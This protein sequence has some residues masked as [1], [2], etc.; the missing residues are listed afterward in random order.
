[1]NKLLASAGLAGAITGASIG[2]YNYGKQNNEPV[3]VK[4]IEESLGDKKRYVVYDPNSFGK[5]N[6]IGSFGVLDVKGTAKNYS[7]YIVESES[8][9]VVASNLKIVEDQVYSIDIIPGCDPKPEPTPIDPDPTSA[10]VPWGITKVKA[11]IAREV[12]DGGEV[13]VCVADTGTDY[14]HPDIKPNLVGGSNH[15]NDWSWLDDQGHGTHVAGTISA[16]LNDRDVVGVSNAKIY[17]AKVLDRYGRGLGSWI[18]E[19][20]VS[21]VEAGAD[22]I[23]MSL[24]SPESAGPSE[25][26]MDAVNWAHSQGV[27]TVCAAGNDSKGVGYPAKGCTYAVTATDN[28]D[29]LASFSSRGPE[30]D[31]SAPGVNVFSLKRGGGVVSFS[32]TS[33]ATPH[34]SGACAMSIAAGLDC[35]LKGDDIGIPVTEQGR[36]GRLNIQKSL[37]Q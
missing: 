13:I 18:A 29:G 33:M 26:I 27:K 9:P 2:S 36:L 32:G 10:I 28:L 25:L 11:L 5:K 19:G 35:D 31:I 16:V 4:K 37:E 20:I 22:V 8:K 3:S 24:G 21:C 12:S 6:M 7:G 34:V 15:V 17:T 30:A 14:N 23:S 1:M